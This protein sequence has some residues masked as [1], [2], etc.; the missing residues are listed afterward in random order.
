MVAEYAGESRRSPTL[1][2]VE[3]GNDALVESPLRRAILD[4]V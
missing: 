4:E 2:R 1:T 3:T